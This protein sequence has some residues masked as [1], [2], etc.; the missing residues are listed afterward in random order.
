MR[1]KAIL[2]TKIEDLANYSEKNITQIIA[3]DLLILD[4]A[5]ISGCLRWLEI[6]FRDFA[7]FSNVFCVG[8]L[9]E[10]V[11]IVITMNAQNAF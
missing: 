2:I 10:R 1:L 6:F 9:T 5:R 7:N 3:G 8:P 11:Y 4:L